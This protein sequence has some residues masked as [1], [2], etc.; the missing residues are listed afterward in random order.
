[1]HGENDTFK[2]WEKKYKIK[3]GEKRG[4]LKLETKNVNGLGRHIIRSKSTK[5]YQD[6]LNNNVV[7]LDVNGEWLVIM[8][9]QKYY[10]LGE[11]L[12]NHMVKQ[13]KVV[14]GI[15]QTAPNLVVPS[16]AFWVAIVIS[17]TL[18]EFIYP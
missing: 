14:R 11:H 9:K 5:T 10:S 18:W 8:T 1:M 12:Q 3:Q 4:K 17:R 2:N 6:M 15:Q 13:I 16:N 7:G